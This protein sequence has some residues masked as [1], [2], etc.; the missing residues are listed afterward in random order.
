M[1][2]LEVVK[3]RLDHAGVGDACLE[4]H[5]NK[6]NKRVFLEEL[7]RV[8]ELG[9]PR[10]EFP[11]T[12]VENLTDARDKLNEHPAR[13]HKL[14]YPSTFSPYQVMGHLVRLR[15]LGQ[16]PTDFI[17]ENFE[18]WDAND[19]AKRL[20]LVKEIIDRIR[21]MGIPDQHPWNGVGLDQ[22]LPMDVEQ[23]I[24][25]LQQI[26]EEIGNLTFTVANL[27]DELAVSPVPETFLSITKLVDMA[28]CIDK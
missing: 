10:G 15:Q 23:L 7:K 22:I 28:E 14:Y 21:D 18:K 12:L 5:S 4:L 8:W 13:L 27:S 20:D 17:L 2:A 24:P 11:D 19:L 26:E 9:S 3:R 16:T 25:R 6:T 1:A